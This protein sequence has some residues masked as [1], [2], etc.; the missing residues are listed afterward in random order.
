[1]Y[2]I[3]IL[4]VTVSIFATYLT[5]FNFQNHTNSITSHA[6][7][8]ISDVECNGKNIVKKHVD[9]VIVLLIQ[10]NSTAIVCITYKFSHDWAGGIADFDILNSVNVTKT[11][12]RSVSTNTTNSQFTDWMKSFNLT[13]IQNSINVT[14]IHAGSTFTVIYKIHAMPKSKGIYDYTLPHGI[15]EQY[16]MAVGY[17]ASQLKVSDFPLDVRLGRS[18]PNFIAYVTSVKI[19]SGM[20][21]T[22]V[23]TNKQ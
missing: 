14:N 7:L 21:Y 9:S 1:M 13:A 11:H 17:N 23:V 5:I 15:C 20:N 6:T 2:V 10:P 3:L 16:P 18:C 4:I 8:P 19:I 12:A 22:E